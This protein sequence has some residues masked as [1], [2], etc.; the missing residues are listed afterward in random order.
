MLEVLKGTLWSFV[1]VVSLSLQ[2][3]LGLVP[4]LS[5]STLTM[6]GESVACGPLSLTEGDLA[7][8]DLSL[9][10]VGN[11]LLLVSSVLFVLQVSTN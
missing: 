9:L 8:L 3:L 10:G 2:L 7:C 6:V 1:V 5:L 4:S 11:I